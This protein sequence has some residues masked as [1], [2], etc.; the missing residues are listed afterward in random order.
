MKS[1][2][3]GQQIDLRLSIG[4]IRTGKRT[5][6]DAIDRHMAANQKREHLIDRRDVLRLKD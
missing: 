1:E 2:K 5:A 6:A 4:P 3:L